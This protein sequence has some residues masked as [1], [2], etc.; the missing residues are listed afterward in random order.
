[1]HRFSRRHFLAEVP[2]LTSA[3]LALT[4]LPAAGLSLLPTPAAGEQPPPLPFSLIDVAGSAGLGSAVNAYGG[5]ATKRYL[6]EETGCGVAF[7]DYD[8]EG[9]LD[10]FFVNGMRLDS[11]LRG[12]PPSN[13]LFRNNR[14]GT[15]TDV[16]QKAGLVRSGWGQGCCVG[17][18]DN[19][20]FDDL[21]VT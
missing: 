1:M 9:W 13:Q 3:A 11:S 19:D 16:T 5:I 17:D 21:F 18:Y 15:F 8:N 20:G 6:L 14:D 10:I 12:Q 2:V 7:F 4:G